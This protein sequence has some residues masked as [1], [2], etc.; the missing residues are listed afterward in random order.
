MTSQA[1]SSLLS[2]TDSRAMRHSLHLS[3]PKR[4]SE[5]ER[6]QEG[7]REDTQRRRGGKRG[8]GPSERCLKSARV[9]EWE[10]SQGITRVG[11][12]LIR[13]GRDRSKRGNMKW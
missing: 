10:P 8:V 9:G 4:E 12:F 11:K 2:P 3:Q 5:R 7:E 1:E 13:I 6:G